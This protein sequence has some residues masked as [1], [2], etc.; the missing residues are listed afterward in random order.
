MVYFKSCEG[1]GVV[2]SKTK[3]RKALGNGQGQNLTLFLFKFYP[4]REKKLSFL[5]YIV[6]LGI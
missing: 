5:Y 6:S 2:F 4:E 1:L 3:K